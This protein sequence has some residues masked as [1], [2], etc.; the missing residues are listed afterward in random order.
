MKRRTHR[1]QKKKTYFKL[2]EYETTGHEERE[3]N[4]L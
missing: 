1:K 3:E 2:T 4:S